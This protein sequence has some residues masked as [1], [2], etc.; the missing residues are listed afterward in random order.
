[1]A[2]TGTADIRDILEAYDEILQGISPAEDRGFILGDFRFLLFLVERTAVLAEVC[3]SRELNPQTKETAE[4][5]PPDLVKALFD[6][7]ATAFEHRAVYLQEV[8]EAEPDNPVFKDLKDYQQILA[9]TL[10]SIQ[11]ASCKTDFLEALATVAPVGGCE[12]GQIRLRVLLPLQ[13]AEAASGHV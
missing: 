11:T 1:M 8:F 7:L 13:H 12:A 6:S 5:F 10:I 3:L 9:S 4:P 2:P